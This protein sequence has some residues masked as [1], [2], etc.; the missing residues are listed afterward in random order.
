MEKDQLQV[1]EFYTK[2]PKNIIKY[3]FDIN[4]IVTKSQITG[5]KGLAIELA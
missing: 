2:R 4:T 1:T 3:K 5:E